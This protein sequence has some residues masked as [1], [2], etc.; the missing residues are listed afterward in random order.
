MC[1]RYSNHVKA[2]LDWSA[3]LGDWPEA[4]PESN[5]IAP[6]QFIVTFCSEGGAAMR[7]GLI[8]SWSNEVSGKYSTFNARIE[9]IAEKPTFRHAWGHSQRCLVPALGYYEWRSEPGG[10]QPYFIFSPDQPLFFA[11]LFEPARGDLIPASC[12]ILT[13]AARPD[14]AEIHTRMPVMLTLDHSQDWFESSAEQAMDLVL[15][16]A[17]PGLK[18]HLVSKKVNNARNEGDDLIEPMDSIVG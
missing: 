18:F 17:G 14:I 2:M 11:G 16:E 4:I 3:L 12:T 10:K 9:S 15:A 7:W 8:P 13:Q 6:S 1:G 5:N